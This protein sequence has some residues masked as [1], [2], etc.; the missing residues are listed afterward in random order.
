MKRIL[1]WLVI[2]IT[3]VVLGLGSAALAL[4][5]MVKQSGIAVGAWS[6][7]LDA[8]GADRGLYTRA[9][10]AVGAV[11]ALNRSET[12][13]FFASSDD[14]GQALDADCDYVLE[15]GDLPARW[16]SI[17]LYAGDHFLIE[18]AANRWSYSGAT[19]AKEA[20][21]RFRITISRNEQPGNWL[22]SG[23]APSL[24]LATRLYNPSAEVAADPTKAPMPTITRGDCR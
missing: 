1:K 8:G 2:A 4:T 12:I 13:Y 20:D 22:P 24:V 3:G 10:V 23:K 19:V 5:Q 9:A 6:T 21:G 11:L 17:T 14:S 18:N 16:W 7:P 15:G